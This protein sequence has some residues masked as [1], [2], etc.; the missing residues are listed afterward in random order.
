M[1]VTS[2]AWR[3][4]SYSGD[5]G[6]NCVEA[7][8]SGLVIAVR[9]SKDQPGPQLSFPVGAWQSFTNQLKTSA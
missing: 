5:N 2:V 8:T 4:S 3:K 6:G 7:G 9:D 1:D